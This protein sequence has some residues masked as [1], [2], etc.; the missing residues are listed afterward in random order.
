MKEKDKLNA[1]I[2]SSFDGLKKK[3]PE[4]LWSQLS[5]SL[6][7]DS[8]DNRQAQAENG[9][10]YTKVRESFSSFSQK[11]PRHIWPSIN[12]Q[13]NIDLVWSRLSRELDHSPAVSWPAYRWAAVLLL[14]MLSFTAGYYLYKPR[15]QAVLSEKTENISP[16]PSLPAEKGLANEAS[17]TPEQP[18][19]DNSKQPAGEPARPDKQGQEDIPTA[20]RQEENIQSLP[21]QL[22]KDIRQKLPAVPGAPL[23]EN[24]EGI[25][26][27][28]GK[29][30]QASGQSND[31]PSGTAAAAY[32]QNNPAESRESNATT[33]AFP[34]EEAKEALSTPLYERGLAAVAG[35]SAFP[36][37]YD[38]ERLPISMPWPE[39]GTF[40]VQPVVLD[41][42]A[43]VQV[44]E[45]G[46]KERIKRTNFS[47]GPVLAYNN[48]WLLNNETRNS[49]DKG[50]LISA[51]RTYKQ[52]LGIAFHY[53]VNPKSALAT[54]FHFISKSGQ[55]YN[56][57]SDG[58]YQKMGL[59]LSYYKLYLQYQRTFFPYGE[60]PFSG[61]TAKAGFYG[62]LLHRKSG[63]IRDTQ[64]TYSSFDYGIRFAFG[65][66]KRINRLIIGY[67]ISGE[68]GL[69]NIFLG[70]GKMPARF[71]KTYTLNL[72]PYLSFRYH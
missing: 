54:E 62:G 5:D 1:K 50:S 51:N 46:K 40:S 42:T 32:A 60:S 36:I 29:K 39:E 63:E 14:L 38:L 68:R 23:Q 25:A 48:S 6:P 70:S 58:Q 34:E 28:S 7:T 20:N 26:A 65:Q 17:S 21:G 66:E 9:Q 33:A 37:P 41:S 13:L 3:A 61:L 24:K 2:K 72:G 71:N 16:S 52:N 59:E 18:E 15:S 8:A 53:S 57:F 44:A 19:S 10:L 45:A 49:F 43:G 22:A 11:A 30:T 31:K 47:L 64:S 35:L 55:E 69:T 4:G 27:G 67:G 56:T 12:R